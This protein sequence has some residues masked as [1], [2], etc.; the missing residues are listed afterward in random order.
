MNTQDT[1]LN[2]LN[3]PDDKFPEDVNFNFNYSRRV[4][5]N[6]QE[7]LIREYIN[8]YGIL[9]KFI[10]TEKINRDDVVFGDFSHMKSNL[11][12]IFDMYMLP[13]NAEGFD[14]SYMFNDLGLFN[15]DNINLFVMKSDVDKTGLDLSTIVSN[16]VILPNNKIMEIT[17]VDWQVPGLNNLYTQDDVKSVYK[18][19]LV[20]YD[21]KLT[22]EIKSKDVYN[23][24]HDINKFSQTTK[25]PTRDELQNEPD[26]YPDFCKEFD[27]VPPVDDA[28]YKEI[29]E[30]ENR[31]KERN[32][33]NHLDG[34][35]D[36]IIKAKTK[37]DS[38]SEIKAYSK[39]TEVNTK[40]EEHPETENDPDVQ[41]EVSVS[42]SSEK[43]VWNGV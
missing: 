14:S 21:N 9:V 28:E 31:A 13:E 40:P 37:Q 4:E 25:T 3:Q 24:F 7:S 23:E 30:I 1:K 15:F 27:E 32:N 20:P 29:Q 41:V 38:E 17:S 39:K 34:F 16:L 33:Y 22:D 18:L 5:Y 8:H 26:I 42:D 36:E 11:K 35:F 2:L 10:K 6:L 12:D 19:S 43:D